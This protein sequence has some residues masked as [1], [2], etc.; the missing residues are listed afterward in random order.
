MTIRMEVAIAL[1]ITITRMRRLTMGITILALMLIMIPTLITIPI[2]IANGSD[3]GFMVKIF[4][5]RVMTVLM[6]RTIT[7]TML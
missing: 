5:M 4:A 2:R 1:V 7:V 6:L 3:E